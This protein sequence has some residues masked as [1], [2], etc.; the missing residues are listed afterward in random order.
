MKL[1]NNSF[2]CT[3]RVYINKATNHHRKDVNQYS[4]VLLL[5]CTNFLLQN[6]LK[7]SSK[8]SKKFKFYN[9]LKFKGFEG[10]EYGMLIFQGFQRPLYTNVSEGI[11]RG[12]VKKE[13]KKK[14]KLCKVSD[15]VLLDT[16][17]PAQ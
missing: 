3:K 5:D 14:K 8:L 17:Q 1:A 12:R 7:K 11:E 9:T 6:I 13:M 16:L 15:T 10:L 4:S 2:H